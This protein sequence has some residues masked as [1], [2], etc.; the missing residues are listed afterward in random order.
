[1]I[2]WTQSHSTLNDSK[3]KFEDTK[4]VNRRR[5]DRQI[6]WSKEKEEKDK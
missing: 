4:G 1:M 6:Q 3:K 2:K 5:T